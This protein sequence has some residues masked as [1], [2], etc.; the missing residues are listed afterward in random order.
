MAKGS[1]SFEALLSRTT[2]PQTPAR[3]GGQPPPTPWV[4]GRQ[5]GA[6]SG[7]LAAR[8]VVRGAGEEG[9]RVTVGTRSR[10]G[11]ILFHLGDHGQLTPLLHASVQLRQRG[12]LCGPW[13]SLHAA[14]VLFKRGLTWVSTDSMQVH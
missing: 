12:L 10:H 4:P 14:P 8:H 6:E 1:R 13:E 11:I 9:A 3:A 2:T 5:G 7:I